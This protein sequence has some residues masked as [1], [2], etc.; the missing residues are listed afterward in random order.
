MVCRWFPPSPVTQNDK[1]TLE[2]QQVLSGGT[3]RIINAALS[4]TFPL[5]ALHY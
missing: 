2:L 1:E 4:L 3:V 5:A